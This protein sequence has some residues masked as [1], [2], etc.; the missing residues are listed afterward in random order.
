MFS[1]L[2]N[3][4]V[5]SATL[6]GSITFLMS[7]IL[8]FNGLESLR[9]LDKTISVTG[10]AEKIVES[11]S[12]K[13]S[14]AIT[15]SAQTYELKGGNNALQSDV[16]KVIDF[17]A[18]KGIAGKAIERAPTELRWCVSILQI[19]ITIVLEIVFVQVED[20]IHFHLAL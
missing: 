5:V 9:S 16:R 18:S 3:T 11:D 17:L 13:W 19:P 12:A 10:S 2:K 1:Y 4:P 14:F 15:R 8:G 7:V 6:V 20:H